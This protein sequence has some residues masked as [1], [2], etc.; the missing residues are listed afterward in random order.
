MS[1]TQTYIQ[2]EAP[3]LPPV[4][5]CAPALAARVLSVQAAARGIERTEKNSHANFKYAPID[6][7]YYMMRPLLDAAGLFVAISEVSTSIEMIGGKP[8]YK[9]VFDI[10]LFDIDGNHLTVR[11]SILT[12]YFGA[13]TAGAALSYI[14]KFFYRT[15]FNIATGEGGEFED[16]EKTH[17][18]DLDAVPPPS[19]KPAAQNNDALDYDFM[20]PPY[21]I[22]KDGVAV[23]KYHNVTQWGAMFKKTLADEESGVSINQNR[24]EV[25]RIFLSLRNDRT[26]TPVQLSNILKAM[27]AFEEPGQPGNPV[28]K[29]PTKKAEENDF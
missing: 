20:G 9:A 28:Q 27:K 2:S 25:N 24:R 8:F 21:R 11:R 4:K 15:T 23:D 26:L 18:D 22:I 1:N 12:Q 19:H 6:T 29:A 14:Q 7:Y 5:L 17:I 10:T 16:T 3:S 13:Q